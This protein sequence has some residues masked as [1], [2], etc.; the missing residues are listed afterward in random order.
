MS[1]PRITRQGRDWTAP[2]YQS[3]W[4]SE[5]ATRYERHEPAARDETAS[6][7][8]WI[9]GLIVMTCFICAVLS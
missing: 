7:L 5:R 8:F 2:T 6:P 3:P 1:G 9:F 4:Q